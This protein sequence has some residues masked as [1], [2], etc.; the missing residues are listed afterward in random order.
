MRQKRLR[1]AQAY[2]NRLE[3]TKPEQDELFECLPVARALFGIELEAAVEKLS[4]QFWIVQV[5]VESYIDDHGDD[6]EFTK[7]I[8]RGMYE[9]S[10]RKGEVNE[11]SETIIQAITAIEKICLPS[12]R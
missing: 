3:K 12:L 9:V 6:T 1:T 8:R 5:D 7:N 4:R 10:P 11:V 2:F